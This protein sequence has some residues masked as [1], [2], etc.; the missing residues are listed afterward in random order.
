M[1]WWEWA[2]PGATVVGACS[3]GAP[4]ADCLHPFSAAADQ[5]LPA[6]S[7]A[8]SITLYHVSPILSTCGSNGG[9][10]LLGEVG[11]IVPVAAARVSSVTSTSTGVSV[12]V[13]GSEK[14]TVEML[15]AAVDA[16]GKGTGMVVSKSVT[17]PASGTANIQAP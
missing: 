7:A 3:A 16:D 5:H 2:P 17:L 1:V 4:A 14:E 12:S 13:V 11:K 8:S 15:F 10:V 9:W 6:T